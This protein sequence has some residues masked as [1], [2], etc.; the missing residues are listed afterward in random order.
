MMAIKILPIEGKRPEWDQMMAGEIYA[1]GGNQAPAIYIP[2]HNPMDPRQALNRSTGYEGMQKGQNAEAMASHVFDYEMLSGQAQPELREMYEPSMVDIEAAGRYEKMSDID[3]MAMDM[4][5]AGRLAPEQ[6]YKIMKEDDR[7][8]EESMMKVFA[9]APADRMQL[10]GPDGKPRQMTGSNMM[11][12]MSRTGDTGVGF[13][14]PHPT[15]SIQTVHTNGGGKKSGGRG[16]SGYDPKQMKDLIASINVANDNYFALLKEQGA[17]DPATISA[18]RGLT[19]LKLTRALYEDPDIQAPLDRASSVSRQISGSNV[20]MAGPDLP[21]MV[22][23]NTG[24][25]QLNLDAVWEGAPVR[26]W[27]WGLMS[28]PNKT[29]PETNKPWTVQDVIEQFKR[30]A[31]TRQ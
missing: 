2:E 31:G 3:K 30:R 5:N 7:K 28:D 29:N 16:E 26:Y 22:T 8:R 21:A 6:V 11:D 25:E 27:L 1:E 24:A 19:Q 12:L 17:D 14:A 23:D 10:T 15:R 20:I 18:R 9:N 4:M 13:K